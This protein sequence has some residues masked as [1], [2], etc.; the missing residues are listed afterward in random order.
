MKDTNRLAGWL[1]HEKL[2]LYRRCQISLGLME[3][4]VGSWKD[5]NSR[6]TGRSPT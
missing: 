3:E 5:W 1:K 6:G 2:A 4:R